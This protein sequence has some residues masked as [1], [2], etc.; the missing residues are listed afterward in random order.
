MA[1]ITSFRGVAHT[2]LCDHLGHLNT[3]HYV[4]FFDDAMQN[5]FHLIGY[6]RDANFGWADVRQHIE[7]KSEILPGS[8]IH[9]DCGLIRVGGK[10][11]SFRQKIYSSDSG[12]LC[13]VN[14]STTV[15]FDISARSAVS[16]PDIIRTNA[17]QFM[18]DDIE[19]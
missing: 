4:G 15:L 14:D 7:Y 18:A 17:D 5:F 12:T 3:R 16:A 11:I 10:A 6:Q 8:L 9:V 13:A 2:W 19:A 1:Y